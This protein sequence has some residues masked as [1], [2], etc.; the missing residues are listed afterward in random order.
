MLAFFYGGYVP[1][2]TRPAYIRGV[3]DYIFH[4]RV[5]HPA[6]SDRHALMDVG[7]DSAGVLFRPH[8]A[9]GFRYLRP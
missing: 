1:E 5:Q 8:F 7:G 3:C 2:Y 6:I 4:G 9:A